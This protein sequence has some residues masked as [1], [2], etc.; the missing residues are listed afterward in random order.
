H[1]NLANQLYDLYESFVENIFPDTIICSLH[2]SRRSPLRCSNSLPCAS[3]HD[4]LLRSLLLS[5][6]TLC[7]FYFV[8]FL[9]TS[10]GCLFLILLIYMQPH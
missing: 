6:I 10:F 8:N 5:L 2:W 4:W 7:C 3:L 9:D 1:N